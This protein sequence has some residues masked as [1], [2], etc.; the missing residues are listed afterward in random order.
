MFRGL[1]YLSDPIVYSHQNCVQL[2]LCGFQSAGCPVRPHLL[3]AQLLVCVGAEIPD[4]LSKVVQAQAEHTLQVK[5]CRL[6]V[7]VL[8]ELLESIDTINTMNNKEGVEINSIQNQYQRH[9]PDGNMC[10]DSHC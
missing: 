7:E 2:N 5:I 8:P 4:E 9:N 1:L 3:D 6:R 10:I